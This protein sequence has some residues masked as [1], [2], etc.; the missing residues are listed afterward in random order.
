M[1]D[2]DF[3]AERLASLIEAEMLLLITPVDQVAI[4]FGTPKQI[5]IRFMTLKEAKQYYR[6][7]HFPPGS[8]GPK[9]LAI[10]KFLE[11]GGKIAY[12]SLTEKYLETLEGKA[13]TTIVRE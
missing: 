4:F 1:I 2:K 6:E 3:A 9:I 11:G 13:G 8:M 12:I 10:I 7:G 5:N